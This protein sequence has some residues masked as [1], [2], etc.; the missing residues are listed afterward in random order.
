M[1]ARSYHDPLQTGPPLRQ[2]WVCVTI[3]AALVLVLAF[4]VLLQL[5]FW[6]ACLQT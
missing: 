4:A 6:R 5:S 2:R 1:L 3:S